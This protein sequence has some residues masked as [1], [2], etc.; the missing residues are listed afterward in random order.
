[1]IS[2]RTADGRDDEA[3]ARLVNTA[4]H[5]EQFFIERDRTNPANVRALMGKGKFLLAEDGSNLA[6]CI[7]MELRGER[8]YFGMLSVEP[9]RQGS[10]VGRALVDAVEKIFREAGCMFSDMKIVNVRTELH[11]LYSRWGY[12]ETGVAPYDDPHPTK[13]PV[14]FVKM[15]KP[16]V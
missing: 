8:G 2:I 16:L 11:D 10:G 13:I 4:F 1:M 7:Y 6:G 12:A 15:S 5:V 14:H 3:V 9:S